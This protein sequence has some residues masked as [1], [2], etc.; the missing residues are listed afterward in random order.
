M[1]RI[2]RLTEGDLRRIVKRSAN[3]ILREYMFDNPLNKTDL[4]GSEVEDEDGSTPEVDS[5]EYD[6]GIDD[7]GMNGPDDNI[8]GFKSPFYGLRGYM[9]NDEEFL[10]NAT[11]DPDFNYFDTDVDCI[12][13]DDY[14]NYIQK[15][16]ESK[17]NLK[18]VIRES[19]NKVL[20]RRRINED[21][22]RF[23]TVPENVAR[24]Y[25]FKPEYNMGNGIEIWGRVLNQHELES[26][27][28][29]LFKLGI[30]SWAG[31]NIN[32][33]VRIYV[34][35]EYTKPEP[36]SWRNKG[37]RKIG[38]YVD[39]EWADKGGAI[40]HNPKNGHIKR[41]NVQDL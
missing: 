29:L 8:E 6:P 17:I 23:E 10:D 3:S 34:E 11:Y 9:D 13:V 7:L 39:T 30:K 12:P 18:R 36:G 37:R 33:H 22:R 5:D 2:I 25:G 27:D 14:E 41:F 38:D 15:R 1:K 4:D 16:N 28:R 24:R 21:S 26:S 20:S 32:G 35:S 19:I 40:F 31:Y